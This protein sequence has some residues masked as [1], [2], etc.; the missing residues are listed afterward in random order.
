M[1]DMTGYLTQLYRITCS[2]RLFPRATCFV[3]VQK[4][5]ITLNRVILAQEVGRAQPPRR[6]RHCRLGGPDMWRCVRGRRRPQQ[7][8]IHPSNPDHAELP[9]P[10]PSKRNW[11]A[12]LVFLLGGGLLLFV[13]CFRCC[14]SGTQYLLDEATSRT[15][16][17][18]YGVDEA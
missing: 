6:C 11:A 14:V 3:W 17:K 12:L 7:P 10:A 18:G 5:A 15:P 13:R 1:I 16:Q 2:S 9:N 8:A 4:F